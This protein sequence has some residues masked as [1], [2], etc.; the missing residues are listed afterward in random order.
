[1]LSGYRGAW[2]QASPVSL[3]LQTVGPLG[4][5]SKLDGLLRSCPYYSLG[6]GE[7]KA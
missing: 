6:D 1:M 2:L 4:R 5:I 7:G 3:G